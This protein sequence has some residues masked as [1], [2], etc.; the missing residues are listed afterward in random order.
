MLWILGACNLEINYPP[1]V[2]NSHKLQ[3]AEEKDEPWVESYLSGDPRV[4]FPCHISGAL[5]QMCLELHSSKSDLLR[6]FT[7]SNL[8]FFDNF[9]FL[10]VS[11]KMH[12]FRV[13]LSKIILIIRLFIILKLS[14]FSI[15]HE[16]VYFS[17]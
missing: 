13:L 4:H 9:P 6:H 5:R 15:V 10:S 1:L 11:A 2:L 7:I 12:L 14:H 3:T 16:S 8:N 17:L